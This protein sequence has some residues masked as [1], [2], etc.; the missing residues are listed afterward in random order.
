MTDLLR[1]KLL[2][3]GNTHGICNEGVEYI[4]TLKID[5]LIGYYLTMI[6]WCAENNYPSYPVITTYFANCEDN[7]IFVGKHFNGETLR[8]KQT[9]VFHRCTGHINVEMNYDKAIIPM[10]YF[11]NGCNMT[12][13]C[14]QQNTPPIRV[15][16][17][18]FGDN[19]ISYEKNDNAVFNKY[20]TPVKA[21]LND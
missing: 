12:I 6:D 16:L 5:E 1:K 20:V 9:Y 10:L 8:D 19:N 15:P 18:T 13:T 7:G 3:E 21:K 11:A 4:N 17:Y 2:D 14:K